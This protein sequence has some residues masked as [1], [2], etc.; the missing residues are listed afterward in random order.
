MSATLPLDECT[1]AIS[2]TF[3]VTHAAIN[4]RIIALGGEPGKSVTANTTYLVSTQADLDKSTTKTKAALKHGIPIVSIDWLDQCEASLDHE[5]YQ[6]YVLISGVAPARSTSAPRQGRSKRPVSPVPSPI[7]APAPAPPLPVRKG[8]GKQPVASPNGSPVHAPAAMVPV[9][10]KSKGKKRA[11]SP[12]LS[13][14]PAP[15]PDVKKAKTVAP[16]FGEGSVVKS[17]DVVVPLD[18]NCFLTSYQVYVDD[19]GIVYDAALNQT[20][21]SNNN[22]KFY[23]VQ[24]RALPMN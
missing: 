20:N 5:D 24:V 2:G 7:I 1:I 10:P 8:R 11:A 22:N 14:P 13:L 4:D 19:I 15:A 3:E 23:R 16:K 6:Q 18:E 9:P 21:A 17:K 12:D